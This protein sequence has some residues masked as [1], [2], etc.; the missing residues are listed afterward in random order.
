MIFAFQMRYR[1]DHVCPTLLDNII[2]ASRPLYLWAISSWN[3]RDGISMKLGCQNAQLKATN[4]GSDVWEKSADSFCC[5]GSSWEVETTSYENGYRVSTCFSGSQD[6]QRP[7][8]CWGAVLG[9]K[10]TYFINHVWCVRVWREKRPRIMYMDTNLIP[11]YSM[12]W[13]LP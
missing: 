10:I 8:R 13:H 3:N 1:R 4:C 6:V 12:L 2:I 5:V 7:S 11:P 9:N